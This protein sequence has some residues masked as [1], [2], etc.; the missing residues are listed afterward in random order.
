M[1][2][3]RAPLDM[4]ALAPPRSPD[5]RGAFNSA[6]R[7]LTE[8]REILY[9]HDDLMSAV[10]QNNA[11]LVKAII[12]SGVDVNGINANGVD[13]GDT[14]LIVAVRKNST[15]IIKVLMDNH[16]DPGIRDRKG[17]TAV[18]VAIKSLHLGAVEALLENGA[19]PN[20]QNPEDIRP[21][22]LA[23]QYGHTKSF[24]KDVFDLLLKRGADVHQVS[25]DKTTLVM[26]AAAHDND[27]AL[28]ALLERKAAIDCISAHGHSALTVAARNNSA[29]AVRILLQAGADVTHVTDEGLN[30]SQEATKAGFP[31]L[32]KVLEA[33]EKKYVENMMKSGTGHETA[34]P[35]TAKFKKR[36]DGQK[37]K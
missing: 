19:S 16:A 27:Y 11:R 7:A 29:K 24:G 35:K 26:M 17:L 3:E 18:N 5:M 28:R 21:L 6:A 33:A 8:K 12:S 15:E 20:A 25:D 32:A 30:A 34:A 1:T 9:T 22:E 14:A 2:G 36:A 10:S 13:A 23:I 31:E 37:P 4:A